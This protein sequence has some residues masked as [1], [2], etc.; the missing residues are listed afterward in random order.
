M[1]RRVEPEGR[2]HILGRNVGPLRRLVLV[3]L[4][5]DIQPGKV[6]QVRVLGA[7]GRQMRERVRIRRVIGVDQNIARRELGGVLEDGRFEFAELLQN[8][9]A[10]LAA[11]EFDRVD[12]GPGF[13]GGMI[14]GRER[15]GEK[16][17]QESGLARRRPAQDI[18]EEHIPLHP[19]CTFPALAGFGQVKR[20]GR[21]CP[22]V[23]GGEAEIGEIG[24]RRRRGE[25]GGHAP[26]GQP[27]L[28]SDVA[29]FV[30]YR[31]GG[32]GRIEP[33]RREAGGGGEEGRQLGR[34]Q[35][36]VIVLIEE[37]EEVDEE[38]VAGG[39]KFDGGVWRNVKF[40]S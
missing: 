32:E 4:Q 1:Q 18:C 27:A 3:G 8:Q 17:V 13:D 10:L 35:P 12:G 40:R 2:C 38:P 22:G 19:G 31:R 20:R 21:G 34:V 24:E 7:Q 23:G 37:E 6:L 36:A 39:R 11:R 9:R 33:G 15:P 28:E 29:G 30:A 25:E 14:R 5:G 16:G 26:L